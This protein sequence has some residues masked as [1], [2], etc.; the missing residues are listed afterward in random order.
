MRLKFSNNY[1]SH[2]IATSVAIAAAEKI[3]MYFREMGF[4][5]YVTVKFVLPG[6]IYAVLLY[7][8]LGQSS[9]QQIKNIRQ[10]MNNK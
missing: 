3:C 2:K 7:F 5:L 4:N 9:D 1:K 8:V 10:E 6:S